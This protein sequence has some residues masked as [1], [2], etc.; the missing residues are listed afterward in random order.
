MELYPAKQ[1]RPNQFKENHTGT[2]ELSLGEHQA[3]H[4]HAQRATTFLSPF[5]LGSPV[6]VESGV[7]YQIHVV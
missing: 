4:K 1:D 6:C 5:V 3:S 2:D 7:S